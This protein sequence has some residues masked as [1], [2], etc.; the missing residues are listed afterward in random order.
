[1]PRT[2]VR[3]VAAGASLLVLLWLG[4]RF[5]V[6]QPS[7]QRDWEYGM[8]TLPH[9]AID[10]DLVHVQHVRDFHWS[11]D[12][13]SSA[14]YVDRSF[15]VQRLER[16]WFVEEPFSMA[17]FSGF[18]GVAHTYFVFDFQDESPV[19][20]SVESRRERGQG[21]DSIHGLFNEYELI[22]IW[23]TEQ[24]LTGR[25]AVLEK[26]QLYMFPLVGSM[27][28]A[29]K[30][31]LD[32][33]EVSRQLETQPRFYNTLTSN[34]TNELAKVANQAQ[35]GTIPPNIA[36][37]FPGYADNLLYDLGLIPNDAPLDTIRQR[38]AITDVVKATIDQP[39]FSRLLRLSLTSR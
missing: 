36:L 15:D 38:Y 30:L 19:A 33:A 1:M 37:I 23:G 9:I 12:G 28:S 5:L 31:F 11:A 29:R 4:Y 25:R 8:E 26:N 16:V 27:D 17:P 32:L 18:E 2:A 7:N 22:Y 35:P 24:D 34:C 39:D 13:S 10:G 14:E 3:L 21:Y 20:I 6:V